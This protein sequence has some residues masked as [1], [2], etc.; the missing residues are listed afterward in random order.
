MERHKKDHRQQL[1]RVREDNEAEV[2]QAR[3]DAHALSR[4][5][6]G[7]KAELKEAAER[8]EA[9]MQLVDAKIRKALGSKDEIITEL[10]TKLR[11]AERKV[12]NA[13]NL[14]EELN[15]GISQIS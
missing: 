10:T 11:I 4:A 13:E 9:E 7:A 2:A 15:Q 14:V 3:R 1:Q 12:K 6:D 5:L 8:H